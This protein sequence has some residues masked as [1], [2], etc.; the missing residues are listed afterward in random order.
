MKVER[1]EREVGKLTHKRPLFIAG[2]DVRT[3]AKTLREAIGRSEQI[4]L[5]RR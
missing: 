2:E 3:I 4:G 1:L 5:R